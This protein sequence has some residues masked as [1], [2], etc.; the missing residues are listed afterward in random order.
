M[1]EPFFNQCIQDIALD[2]GLYAL[3]L[4]YAGTDATAELSAL[5]QGSLSQGRAESSRR[6]SVPSELSL[7][8]KAKAS[9]RR[10]P[11]VGVRGPSSGWLRMERRRV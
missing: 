9:V 3:E 11:K 1:Y 5:S 6:D 2:K 10:A 4:E 8:D 7:D